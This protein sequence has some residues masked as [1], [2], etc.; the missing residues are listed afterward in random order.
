MT[1]QKK[2][3]NEFD[4]YI[5][6]DY[7]KDL[8]G[9]III[10]NEKIKDILPKITK[11]HHYKGLRHK[12]E[13]LSAIRRRFE[14]DKIEE[15]L[16]RFEIKPLRNNVYLFSEVFEFVKKYDNCIIFLSIDN[17]QYDAFIRLFNMIEHKDNV[18]IIKENKLKK[19]SIEY[20]L[21]LIID[22]LLNVKRR[23][24]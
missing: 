9:Y 2:P 12:R 4:Y 19:Y 11:L 15:D 20:K 7:S 1:P 14:K 21:S 16:L 6:I 24:K 18:R 17:N 22:N 23:L 8:I 5:F 13:Y 3:K 10:E